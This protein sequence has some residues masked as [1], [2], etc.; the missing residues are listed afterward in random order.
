[1]ISQL[2]TYVVNRGKMDEWLKIFYGRIV[3][4][5]DKY[6]IV[7]GDCWVTPD[8]SRFIWVRSFGSAEE[9]PV[10]EETFRNSPEWKA[11]SADALA[12][13]AR[14]DVQVIEPVSAS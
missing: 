10:K 6:G 8:R 12:T 1:M 9:I 4:I 14:F 7:V 5:H 13:L 3:P 2:R 11:V